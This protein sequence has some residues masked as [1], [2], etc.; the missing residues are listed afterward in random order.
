MQLI[1]ALPYDYQSD[2]NIVMALY[3]MHLAQGHGIKCHTITSGT[4]ERYLMA[5][6]AIS[7]AH[8]QPDPRLNS[9]GTTSPYITK[10]LD[11]LRHWETMPN[12]RESV[13]VA[14][15]KHMHDMCVIQHEDS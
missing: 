2:R 10:V 13:T 11:E 6:A 4:I 9:R 3:A 12:R 1:P 7:E 5:A 15:M 8:K 14:I